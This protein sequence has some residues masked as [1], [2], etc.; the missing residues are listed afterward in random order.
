ME[1]SKE[2]KRYILVAIAGIAIAAYIIPT[3]GLTALTQVSGQSTECES[4]DGGAGGAGG[5]ATSI[6]DNAITQTDTTAD[7]YGNTAS[8]VN[9][10]SANADAS[11]GN[12]G[13]GGSCAVGGTGLSWLLGYAGDG[14]AGGA[15]GVATAILSN[16]IVQSNIG[17]G[18]STNTNDATLINTGSASAI[19]NGGDGGDGGYGGDGGAG[20]DGGTATAILSNS[21]V[22][23]NI[24]TGSR[25]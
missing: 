4:G 2:M 5:E 15:G 7:E 13:A 19:A 16:S 14:G 6:L 8:L 17:Y 23:S 20:G 10:G 18:S 1:I 11:G 9:V 25:Y 3:T 12:G 22:Q 24:G 21:I